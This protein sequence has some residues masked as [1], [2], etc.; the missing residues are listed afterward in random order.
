MNW[1]GD[2]GDRGMRSWGELKLKLNLTALHLALRTGEPSELE[3]EPFDGVR[4]R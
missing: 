3:R 2:N 1:Q 4:Q